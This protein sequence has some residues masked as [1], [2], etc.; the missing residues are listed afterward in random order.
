MH[1]NVWEWTASGIAQAPG[2]RIIRGGHYS[3]PGDHC[4]A[5]MRGIAFPARPD[6]TVGFRVMFR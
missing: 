5:G 1:G 4:R 2:R 3:A 6:P